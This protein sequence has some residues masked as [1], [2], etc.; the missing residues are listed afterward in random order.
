M[1]K[2]YERKNYEAHNNKSL[3]PPIDIVDM[4]HSYFV[5]GNEAYRV[6][7]APSDVFRSAVLDLAPYWAHR[8]EEHGPLLATEI[9]IWSRWYLLCELAA[10]DRPMPLYPSRE[11]A[12]AA[13]G[14]LALRV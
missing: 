11:S 9:D 6:A 2:A 1:K 14:V 5:Y 10:T 12:E 7:D 13:C 8:N 4:K 3:L